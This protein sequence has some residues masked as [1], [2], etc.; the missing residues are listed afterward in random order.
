[1]VGK[2]IKNKIT[3]KTHLG[4][5]LSVFALNSL[6]GELDSLNLQSAEKN[7]STQELFKIEVRL[8]EIKDILNASIRLARI[9]DSGLFLIKGDN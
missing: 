1:V 5:P 8:G 3:K 2:M 4:K 7:L 9:R 6:R